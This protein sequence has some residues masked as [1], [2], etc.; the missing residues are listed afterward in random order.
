MSNC[1]GTPPFL[2]SLRV[3]M[4][5]MHFHIAQAGL[6]TILFRIK[7]VQMNNFAPMKIRPGEVHG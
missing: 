3:A 4:E 2:N 7:G 6:R 1:V 5:T